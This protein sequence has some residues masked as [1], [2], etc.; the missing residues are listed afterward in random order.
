M[1]ATLLTM[2]AILSGTI[3]FMKKDEN[4]R[5]AASQAATTIHI[6]HLDSSSLGRNIAKV[7]SSIQTPRR[8]FVQAYDAPSHDFQTG[9]D[10]DVLHY[11]ADAAPYLDCGIDLETSGGS[12][13]S[14][15]F[16]DVWITLAEYRLRSAPLLTLLTAARC[17]MFAVGFFAL[18]PRCRAAMSVPSDLVRRGG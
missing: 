14:V 18:I 8:R 17:Q 12:S 16:D 6:S 7:D 2:A 4:T 13:A 9:R 15:D 1:K 3:V 11:R 10:G 5:N